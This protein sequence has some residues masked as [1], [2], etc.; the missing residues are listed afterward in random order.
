MEVKILRPST[1]FFDSNPPDF[2]ICSNIASI[3]S[4][5]FYMDVLDRLSWLCIIHK[6]IFGYDI[7]VYDHK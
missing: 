4:L 2:D 1:R 5:F 6:M 3:G 7:S